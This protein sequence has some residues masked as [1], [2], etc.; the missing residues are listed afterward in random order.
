[1]VLVEV[2]GHS[3]L[4]EPDLPALEA[5]IGFRLESMGL[6]NEHHA[7]EDIATRIARKRI[8]ANIMVANGPVSAGGDQQRDAESYVTHIPAEL[9]RAAG[10]SAS[11]LQEAV[12]I[13]C[14]VQRTDLKSKVLKDLKGI[15]ATTASPVG[16]IT[17]FSVTSIPESITHELQQIARD[18]YAVTL[19]V[20]SGNKIATMLAEPDLVWI[21]QH[22]LDV[23]SG[24]IPTVPTPTAPMWYIGMLDAFRANEGPAAISPAAQGEVT[25]ALR[26]AT[27]DANAAADLP[28]LIEYMSQFLT[29][30]EDQEL[31][32]RAC[33]EISVAQFRGIGRV[34]HNETLIRQA[35]DIAG[36]TDK[37]GVL[38]DA[39]TLLA[40]WGN[41]WTSGVGHATA[42]E[43]SSGREQL[44]E[45]LMR[46]L[47]A[48]DKT[49]YPVKTA[50]LTGALAYI[51]LLFRWDEAEKKGFKPPRVD[52]AAN[53]GVDL[54]DSDVRIDANQAK[55]GVFGNVDEAM[56]YL[57]DLVD[58]LP[59][60][61]VYSPRSLGRMF[62]MFAPVL[63][64]NKHYTKVRDALDSAVAESEGDAAIAQRCLERALSFATAGQIL[65]AI[66]DLHQAKVRW[67]HGD[68]L[69]G[70]IL[71]SRYL[72]QLYNDLGLS[73]AAKMY[74]FGSAM[75]ANHSQDL[76]DKTHLSKA[77]IEGANYAH[78]AGQ[79]F[80]AFGYTE[81]AL[82][83]HDLYDSDPLD[84]AKH[85]E[86]DKR[87]VNEVLALVAVRAFWPD[88][89]APMAS[90]HPRMGWYEHLSEWAA[91]SDS[92]MPFSE[93]QYQELAREQFIGP[94]LSD[95]GPTRSIAFSVLGV[96]WKFTYVNSLTSALV[97]EELIAALQVFLVEVA[98]QD[99][100]LFAVT[101]EVNITVV[102]GVPAEVNL[103]EI[104]AGETT[105]VLEV[106]LADNMATLDEHARWLAVASM[107]LLDCVHGREM[108][109]LFDSIEPLIRDGLAHKMLLG[110]PYRESA[111]LL[112]EEHY[113][114]CA[115]Y[116]PP[117]TSVPFEPQSHAMLAASRAYGPGYSQEV[118]LSRIRDRYEIAESWSLSLA[119]F[120]ADGRGRD[121]LARL[122][123]D[124]WL[125]W[126]FLAIFV[127][128]GMNWRLSRESE[129]FLSVSGD[130]ARQLAMLNEDP[131]DP[132][133]PVEYVLEHFN[134]VAYAQSA[135]VALRWGIQAAGKAGGSAAL[136]DLLVRRYGHGVDDVPHRSI[137][138][139]L[140]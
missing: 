7:F 56:K 77:L 11:T 120:C 107:Q 112:S 32:F 76:A 19:N 115:A 138:E 98:S 24:L 102:P 6:R 137:C 60:A 73:Y 113:A 26:F 40:Y 36:N 135:A 65:E 16:L 5:F 61:R 108:Q 64:E 45:H 96:T 29:S 57:N 39:I 30:G 93:A 104:M 52:V 92:A 25:E 84:L 97:A 118:S 140:A 127:N 123:G 23:P 41:M 53:V 63:V 67:F 126:H 69:Y 106:T 91:R 44:R 125:D 90:L 68:T 89:E 99:P 136:R 133:M 121:L 70:T 49:V 87:R 42:A 119:H 59:N 3:W 71:V 94:L 2:I 22:Y 88:L 46:L 18:V 101:V 66:H 95:L 111:N 105:A 129:G 48:T 83:A 80:D 139:P 38:E 114:Q 62:T 17:F 75:M 35:L 4:M 27:Y 13:A 124:G 130:R 131:A 103:V 9:P 79:W 28:E 10:F 78:G 109:D 20:L 34:G 72:G 37:I 43:I 86:L 132:R 1:M 81:M 8:S 100:V 55:L 58:L 33:Y 110:R 74:A 14:T 47:E 31:V 82:L 122:Q 134:E 21:A 85:S 50:A 116:M 128:I 15:C 12:V 54:S 117:E 51:N